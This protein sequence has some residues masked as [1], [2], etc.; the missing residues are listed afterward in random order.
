MDE[1][2]ARRRL[3]GAES[4]ELVDLYQRASTHLSMIQA[5]APDPATV[6]RLS[7]SLA[8]ARARIAGAGSRGWEAVAQFFIVDFPVT[9]WRARWWWIGAGVGFVAAGFAVGAWVAGDP[10]VQ[11]ALASKTDISALVNHDFE[12]YYSSGPAGSFAAKVWTNNA[13]AAA[14]ALLLGTM[15]CLP[16]VYVLWQNALNVGL[17]G[18]LMASAGRL[19]LFFGLITPHGLLE[20]TSVFVAAGVGMRLGWQW[21]DPGRRPRSVALAQEGRAAIVVALGLVLVL[22]ICGVIEAFVTP[23]GLGTP[24]RIAIG[25]SAWLGFL[26]YVAY[27]GRRAGAASGDVLDPS[28]REDVLPYAG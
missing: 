24:V 12:N 6:G 5:G 1:L 9:V 19:D 14:A 8:R 27:F 15:L 20:L 16:A 2:S 3:T 10:Q 17:T 4:E 13:W 11:A 28:A 22:A 23:S 21:I 25:A 26:G 7:Q 18:G